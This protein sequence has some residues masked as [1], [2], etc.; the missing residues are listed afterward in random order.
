MHTYPTFGQCLK[1]ILDSR[2]LS[3]QEGARLMEM[4]SATS[5]SRI[6]HDEVG[7]KTLE[8]FHFSLLNNPNFSLL[9]EE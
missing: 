9:P 5:L 3:L 7:V 2:E 6:I 1:S 4:K 8:K